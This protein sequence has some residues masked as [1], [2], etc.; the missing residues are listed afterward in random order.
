MLSIVLSYLLFK[1]HVSETGFCLRFQLKPTQLG[2]IVGA[3]LILRRPTTSVGFIKLT[4]YKPTRTGDISPHKSGL[5]SVHMHCQQMSSLKRQFVILWTRNAVWLHS[6]RDKHRLRLS[7]NTV[8]RALVRPRWLLSLRDKH[9]LRLPDNT[10]F[11]TTARPRWLLFTR[12]TQIK[13]I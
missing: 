4:Q 8:F 1:T 10:V 2:P 5:T 3:S 12:Q 13:T 6:L 9:R 11:R 7:D